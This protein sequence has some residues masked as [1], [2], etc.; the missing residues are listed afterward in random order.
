MTWGLYTIIIHEYQNL[1][2]KCLRN[3]AIAL[4]VISEICYVRIQFS[5][6]G[7][8]LQKTVPLKL[9]NNSQLLQ[10]YQNICDKCNS[11]KPPRA[12]HCKRCNK[13]IFKMDH[14]CEWT[15]NCVGALNQKYFVL[16][17]LYMFC[18]I[19]TILLIHILWI[20]SFFMTNYLDIW[21]SL[22]ANQFE[23]FEVILAITMCSFFS[24]F[25][26]SMLQDQIQVIRDN[27]TVVESFQGKFG[28]Q[29]SFLQN[30][31]QFM[32]DEKWYYW[33]L[34]TTPILKLNY[35]EIVYGESL[36]NMGTSYLEDIIYDEKNPQSAYFAE[37]M[38]DNYKKKKA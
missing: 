30:M 34:P 19:I 4:W 22:K 10:Y 3:I 6:P 32:G 29:Q 23:I 1:L 11:W 7:E 16:F 8:I 33:M 21:N 35:A 13:C 38:V 17:L 2:I 27:Q 12:H 37:F 9:L 15:N 18:Y 5:D 28:R 36:V 20:Y 31:K 25:V 26:I 24:F 14:H